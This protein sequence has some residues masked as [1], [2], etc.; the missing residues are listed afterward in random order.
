MNKTGLRACCSINFILHTTAFTACITVYVHF[1]NLYF[2]L[3]EL[4]II[5]RTT[6]CAV[7][8]SSHRGLSIGK[9]SG[10]V[11]HIKQYI[12][13]TVITTKKRSLTSNSLKQ[14]AWISLF[15]MMQIELKIYQFYIYLY[16]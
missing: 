14:E 5:N 3:Y 1:V 16:I 15:K 10:H 11:D 6:L 4:L 2:N 9:I 8:G 12:K 13:H 7:L